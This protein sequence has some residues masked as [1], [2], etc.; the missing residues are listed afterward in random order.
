MRLPNTYQAARSSRAQI[1]SL[2]S[3]VNGKA[4]TQGHASG[5]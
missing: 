2:F 4:S 5:A 1:S 3:L